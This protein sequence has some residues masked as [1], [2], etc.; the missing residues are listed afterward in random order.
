MTF[1]SFDV[2]VP[3]RLC[4]LGEHTDWAG[5]YTT[6]NNDVVNGMVLVCAT[7]EGLYATCREIS[8][9][10]DIQFDHVSD[11]G[12]V[13][14]I[15]MTLN[16]E[17]LT[18]VAQSSNFASYIAGT[19]AELI[20]SRFMQETFPSGLLTG[21]HI[22]NW[23]TTLPMKKGLSSSAAVC[24]LVASCFNAVYSLNMSQEDIM[25]VA[26]KGEMRT[27]SRCGRMDQ[28]VVMGSSAIGYMEFDGDQCVLKKIQCGKTLFFV[29]VDLMASKDTIVILR[30]LNN[31][32]PFAADDTQKLMHKYQIES[33]KNSLQAMEAIVSGSVDT[34]SACIK[35]GQQIFDECAIPNCP[36][37]LT[38]PIL[39]K[40]INDPHLQD[41]SLAVKGIGSQGDGSA[42]VLC[43][44][45]SSQTAVLQYLREAYTYEAFPLTIPASD[46]KEVNYLHTQ[47][48]GQRLS[49]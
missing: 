43:R 38:A 27:P 17:E 18:K 22:N 29:V 46:T 12:D 33:K 32:F 8:D 14:S 28:C 44:D 5:K 6:D 21:I 1:Q 15:S 7:N 35:R 26:Y 4:I 2:F 31:C 49:E 10:I 40:L 45:L 42:Q 23:K 3:G 13:S 34:L 25:E 11:E 47:P 16:I 48:V 9:S 39:H 24:V 36:S 20:G 41:I 37:Q 19:A 30:Q